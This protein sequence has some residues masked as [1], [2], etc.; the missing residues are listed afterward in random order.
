[1]TTFRVRTPSTNTPVKLLHQ[2]VAGPGHTSSWKSGIAQLYSWATS[3][4]RAWTTPS[5]DRGTDLPANWK[6]LWAGRNPH[7]AGP[8]LADQ[9]VMWRVQGQIM[10]KGLQPPGVPPGGWTLLP[11]TSAQLSRAQIAASPVLDTLTSRTTRRV[12]SRFSDRPRTPAVGSS[13]SSSGT[14]LTVRRAI[15]AVRGPSPQ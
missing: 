5:S 6:A 8:L 3:A 4:N 2:Q 10:V 14:A 13:L 9:D 15:P 1:M 12:T 7:P 11:L